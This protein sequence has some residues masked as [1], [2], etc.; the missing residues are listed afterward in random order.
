MGTLNVE[1]E[2]KRKTRAKLLSNFN[3]NSGLQEMS[4]SLLLF[5]ACSFE[6]LNLHHR[7]NWC[8][9]VL[10]TAFVMKGLQAVNYVTIISDIILLSI[11]KRNVTIKIIPL[12]AE[13][14]M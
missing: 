6:S 14:F 12:Q 4:V 7:R 10:R 13:L 1:R 5:Q 8:D 2:Q 11:I 9:F 3:S